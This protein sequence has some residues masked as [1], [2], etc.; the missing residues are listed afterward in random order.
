ME[1]KWKL[2]WTKLLPQKRTRVFTR[3][4]LGGNPFTRDFSLGIYNS[5]EEMKIMYNGWERW[6]TTTGMKITF[7]A[8]MAT[9]YDEETPK[10]KMSD[11]SEDDKNIG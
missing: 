3:L 5:E 9:W 10:Y 6:I 2:M 11:E 8:V 1:Y 7:H 4:I